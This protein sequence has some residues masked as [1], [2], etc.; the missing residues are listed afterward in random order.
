M[1]QAILSFDKVHIS[2]G[3]KPV[4]EQLALH[5]GPGEVHAIMGPN[6]SG[7]STLAHA[8][9]G[10]PAYTIQEG[11]VLFE[12]Q[13]ILTW[14]ADKRARAGIFLAFQQPPSIPGL[15][16]FTFLHEAHAAVTGQR[17]SVTDFE[18]RLRETMA[19]LSIDP[20]FVY[21]DLN[22]GFSG[23]EKKRFE[24]LQM[25]LLEPKLVILDEI[26]SGLDIDALKLVANGIKH[27]QQKNP[28]LALVIITHYQ[29]ILHYLTPDYV[30]I[31]CKG[32]I[33][34]SGD[35][36]LVDELEK[37]GYDDYR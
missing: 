3:K 15:S 24:L 13:S 19:E 28:N 9:A 1:S 22:D 31:L 21:R 10:H 11:D 18:R 17:V 23:G 25:V 26:D 4:I 35:A 5:V 20:A 36:T 32:R 7:K 14:S 8:L 37:Q 27:A 33:V 16:V 29:R 2:V 6:G 12:G 34:R 30:H